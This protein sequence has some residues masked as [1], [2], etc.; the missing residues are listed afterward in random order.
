[1]SDKMISLSALTFMRLVLYYS[2]GYQF[3]FEGMFTEPQLIRKKL[4]K[5]LLELKWIIL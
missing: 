3:N 4:K 1:M 2:G 5:Q